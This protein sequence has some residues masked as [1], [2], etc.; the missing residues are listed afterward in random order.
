MSTSTTGAPRVPEKP[1]LDDL[2]ERWASAWEEAGT[3]RFDDSATRDEV[4]SI[5]TPPPTVSGLASHG[6]RVRL[7]ADRRHRPLPAHAGVEA[8]LPHGLGRQRAPDRA[9]GADLLRGHLRPVAPLRPGLRAARG[10]G[11]GRRPGQPAQLHRAVPPAHRRGRAGLR[12]PVAAGGALG[13]LG[14]RLRHHRRQ[15]P[16]DQPAH[17]P[18]QPGAGRGLH[19]GGA[20]AVGRRLPD[21]RGPGRDGGPR[22][23]RAPTTACASTTS[24]SRRPGPSCVAACV[25]LVAHP[26]DERY[27]H[28]LRLDR[29]HAA[30]R[31]RG[32]RAGAPPRRAGQGLGHR[33]DLHLRRRHRRRVVARARSADAEHRDPLGPH[34]RDT[35][36]RA[37][38]TARPGAPSPAGRSSRPSGPWSRCW[39]HRGTWSATPGRSTHPVKFYERGD[40]PARD[41][42]QPAVVHPQRRPRRARCGA[43]CWRP[44]TQLDWHP[45]YMQVRYDDWVNGLNG[46]WLV[47]RQRF[48]GVPIPVW[49]PLGPDG[50]PDY[51][52]P[53]VPDESTPPRRPDDR[54]A[55]RLHAEAAR[56]ARRL[57]RRPRRHGHLGH[58]VGDPADRLR[59]GGR[60]GAAS[61]RPSRWTCGRRGPRSSAPGCSPPC[62]ARTSSTTCCR[63]GT[64]PST[65]GSSTRTARRCPSRRATWSPRW[66]PWRSSAPTPCATGPAT[67][68]RAPT[69]RSTRAS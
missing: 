27:A 26:D 40:P 68:G 64:P 35:A 49:Y 19:V 15:E 59:L 67:D 10:A 24:R 17:V 45:P 3:Y 20:D 48:F 44:G 8:L 66:R 42:D 56:R 31:G 53:I 69:P 32:A 51:D 9:P 55:R 22:A 34:H 57:H 12:G 30:L 16:A 25:A 13:R 5:D 46:D 41:R 65:A 36:A 2:E 6:L 61:P 23:E 28:P 54:R 7:R 50:E 60:P 1:T 47:S 33:H 4:F 14:P 63:G 39:P 11:Q 29:A 37:C 58:L 43:S 38:P 18:A 62:C 21:G 52:S